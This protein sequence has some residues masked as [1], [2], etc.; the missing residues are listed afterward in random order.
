MLPVSRKKSNRGRRN[1]Q[2][3]PPDPPQPITLPPPTPESKTDLYGLIVG[4]LSGFFFAVVF[5]PDNAFTL[6]SAWACS[7]VVLVLSIF[8]F[9]QKSRLVNGAFIVIGLTIIAVSAFYQTQD[10]LRPSFVYIVP[11]FEIVGPQRAWAFL[12]RPQGP[13]TVF[14]AQIM[15]IDIDKRDEVTRSGKQVLDATDIAS[16]MTIVRYP[17]ISK[18]NL[19][20]L[21]PKAIILI[22]Y[23]F[24]DSHFEAAITWRD[25]GIHEDLAVARIRGK[26]NYRISVSDGTTGKLLVHCRDA[27]YP[28]LEAL[29]VCFP[30]LTTAPIE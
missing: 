14:N 8:K 12:A 21:S 13:N 5:V 10:R 24:E 9:S 27:D 30:R 4:V 17:E 15:L 2:P 18:H 22:P 7:A 11:G 23:E 26:W 20:A 3:N 1:K 16:Y 6:Y 19:N 28:S 29:P 25:G